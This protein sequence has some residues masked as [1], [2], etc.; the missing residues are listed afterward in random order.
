MHI[1][2]LDYTPL[3]DKNSYVI[4]RPDVDNIQ[5]YIDNMDSVIVGHISKEDK[6]F[7]MYNHRN[8][9]AD[10]KSAFIQLEIMRQD[11]EYYKKLLKKCK[12]I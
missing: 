6:S 2:F 12:L 5:K 10:L 4:E 11:I 3:K 1:K 9:L 8:M 7:L